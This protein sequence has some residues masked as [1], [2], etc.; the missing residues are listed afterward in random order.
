MPR[1]ICGVSV[2]FKSLCLHVPEDAGGK[3]HT[4]ISK[5]FFTDFTL[6]CVTVSFGAFLFAPYFYTEARWRH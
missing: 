3:T 4:L 2:F 6:P 1:A 5:V